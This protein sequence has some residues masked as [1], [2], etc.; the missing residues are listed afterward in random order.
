MGG[1]GLSPSTPNCAPPPPTHTPRGWTTHARTRTPSHTCCTT[2]PSLHTYPNSKHWS[3]ST[4]L[5]YIL[6]LLNTPQPLAQE[7]ASHPHTAPW[8]PPQLLKMQNSCP[9]PALQA[10]VFPSEHTRQ[11]PCAPHPHTHA[12]ARTDGPASALPSRAPH[13]FP[14]TPPTGK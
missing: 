13:P 5:P 9:A 12:R 4:R 6:A 1:E 2:Q 3:V 7:R 8:L 11:V 14:T 10:T